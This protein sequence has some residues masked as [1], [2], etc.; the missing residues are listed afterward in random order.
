[1]RTIVVGIIY[2]EMEQY[3]NDYIDSI[4][5]QTDKDFELFLFNNGIVDCSNYAERIKNVK[6]KIIPLNNCK[7]V[8]ERRRAVSNTLLEEKDVENIIFTDTDDFFDDNRIEVLK[9]ALESNKIVFTDLEAVD[10]DGNSLERNFIPV[11]MFQ[12]GFND[13][14]N[15]H[16]VGFG[17]SAMKWNLLHKVWPYQDNLKVGDWWFFMSLFS[18]GYKAFK[19]T[20]TIYY[21]RQY[22]K[23]IAGMKVNFDEKNI[24][25]NLSIKEEQYNAMLQFLS[26]EKR[27]IIQMELNNLLVLKGLLSDKENM[28]KYLEN[29][30][31]IAKTKMF[32]WREH[33]DLK[34][35]EQ[36]ITKIGKK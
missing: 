12:V 17:H 3:F 29:I 6:V 35:M 14:V 22:D 34:Y 21:Y 26:G 30:N 10:V 33:I 16:F 31:T 18:Q 27:E 11:D 24:W 7:D 15:K 2:P 20:G 13:E 1:M 32:L 4:N 25:W 23:N 8:I 5:K 36:G 9:N 19:V 28:T